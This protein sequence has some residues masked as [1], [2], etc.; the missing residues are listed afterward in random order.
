MSDMFR[1][2]IFSCAV[3]AAHAIGVRYEDFCKGHECFMRLPTDKNH[4]SEKDAS[5]KAFADARGGVITNFQTREYAVWFEN[6]ESGQKLTKAQRRELARA[7]R[8]AEAARQLEQRKKHEQRANDA[9]YLWAASEPVSNH[10]Y[11]LSKHVC[12][13]ETMRQISHDKALSI[14]NEIWRREFNNPNYE[15]MFINGS[16]GVLARGKLLVIPL[17][18]DV[19][20][21]Q[22]I[23]LI[24]ATG[25]KYFLGGGKKKG[26]YWLTGK[27]TDNPGRVGIA[28]GVATALSVYMVHGFP[29]YS[30]MDCGNLK[31]VARK[32]RAK[33]PAARID[34][35]SDV[36]NG[37]AEAWEAAKACQGFLSVPAFDD[38][39]IERFKAITGSDKPTDFNDYYIAKGAI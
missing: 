22:T 15:K 38:D 37:E 8:E 20:A 30:A 34:I 12:A 31:E 11:L 14:L 36:G 9:S 24:D 1:V 2:G 21:V 7:R 17:K 23:Q 6:Y 32:V 10:P 3:D 33:Y 39:L 28:E 19:A 13:T 18:G 4:G 16:K 5:L 26:A 27:V 35:L 25:S 29:V